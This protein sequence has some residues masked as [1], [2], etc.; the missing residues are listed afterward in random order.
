MEEA[1]AEDDE[2]AKTKAVV[3]TKK[4]KKRTSPSEDDLAF[5][6]FYGQLKDWGSTLGQEEARHRWRGMNQQIRNRFVARVKRRKAKEEG[7][8]KRRRRKEEPKTPTM[9]STTTRKKGKT[10]RRPFLTFSAREGGRMEAEAARRGDP[11]PGLAAKARELTRRWAEMDQTE[12][13]RYKENEEEQR[14]DK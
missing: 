7:E 3:R 8:S 1:K 12:R 11:R 2:R 4:R 13:D 14:S 6:E 9:T 10:Q 5:L